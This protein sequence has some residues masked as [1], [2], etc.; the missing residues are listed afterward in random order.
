MYVCVCDRK[1]RI[2]TRAYQQALSLSLTV[3]L[4]CTHAH[5]LT[6]TQTHLHGSSGTVYSPAACFLSILLGTAPILYMTVCSAQGTVRS[7]PCASA[8]REGGAPGL[9]PSRVGFTIQTIFP[10]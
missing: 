8:I 4:T 10:S 5:M 6:Y 3:S 2:H 1:E 7:V 9:S